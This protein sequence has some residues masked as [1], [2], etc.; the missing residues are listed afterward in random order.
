VLNRSNGIGR[1]RRWARRRLAAIVLF[2]L[3]LPAL[4]LV[5]ETVAYAKFS[6]L[7]TVTHTQL[8][9][10]GNDFSAAVN[11]P[12]AY[13]YYTDTVS[14]D[15]FDS[16]LAARGFQIDLVPLSSTETFNFSG[17]RSIII[18]SDTGSFNSWGTPA[19]VNNIN[20]SGKRVLGV[21]EGGYA[22]FGQLSLVVGYP[23]GM[24]T[25]SRAAYVMDPTEPS[26]RC[27]NLISIP[28]DRTLAIYSSDVDDIEI[29]I[30]G[31]PPGGV[32][33]I[34]SEPG[35]QT[36]Y[37]LISQRVGSQVY[38]LWGFSGA[39]SAM[40]AAGQDLFINVL[41]PAPCAPLSPQTYLPLI[42]RGP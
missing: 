40:T 10:E 6:R 34:G 26:F 28:P 42:S 23:N 32:S 11:G 33:L 17:D 21:G 19:A 2:A 15:S 1:H 27:P 25:L 4:V 13:V 22:F 8:G 29:Y 7:P 14:R 35:D 37:P 31:T 5:S 18:G 9:P 20:G 24:R 30:S 3:T 36:H 16:F 12:V 41:D 38:F 39:P